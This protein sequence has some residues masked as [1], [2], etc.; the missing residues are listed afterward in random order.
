[1]DREI[2]RSPTKEMRPHFSLTWLLF[3]FSNS[4]I[5]LKNK[6]IHYFSKKRHTLCGTLYIKFTQH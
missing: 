5:D 1:M 4:N 3:K 6:I 2:E